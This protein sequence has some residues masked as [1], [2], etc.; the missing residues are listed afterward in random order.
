[1]SDVIR[2]GVNGAGGRMGRRIVALTHADAALGSAESRP[3]LSQ[4]ESGWQRRGDFFR[5][6]SAGKRVAVAVISWYSV[7]AT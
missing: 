7:L 4:V 1:M 2:V 5:L 3:Q 6:L